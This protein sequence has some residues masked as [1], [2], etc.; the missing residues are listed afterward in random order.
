MTSPRPMYAKMRLSTYQ[1]GLDGE[2]V[3]ERRLPVTVI[4]HPALMAQ[5][6]AWPAC[7]CPSCRTGPVRHGR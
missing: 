5:P 2:R 1:L 4:G 7:R 3:G 6:L